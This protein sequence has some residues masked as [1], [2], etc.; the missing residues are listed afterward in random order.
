MTLI[1]RETHVDG[2][3]F[4]EG[5]ILSRGEDEIPPFTPRSFG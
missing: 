4:D 5:S 2:F 3:R 1:I